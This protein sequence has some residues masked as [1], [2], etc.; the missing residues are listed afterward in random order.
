MTKKEK[1]Q[2]A[3][4]IAIV[5][6]LIALSIYLF[7]IRDRIQYLEVYGYPGIFV[8][9]LL[10]NATVIVPLP[11]VLITSAMGAVFNP[12]WVAVA[13]GTGA[14][15]GELSGY[16]AGFS[17]R[18]LIQRVSKYEKLILWMK[19]YGGVAIFLLAFIPNPAFDMAGITAGSLKVPVTRFLFW[20]LLGKF[21]KML[22][23]A[24]GGATILE[25]LPFQ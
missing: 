4:R 23:F 9:S 16:L 6:V 3:A 14:A 15:I 11:G 18:V 19:K 22:L 5:V 17:G 8:I 13:A 12:F 24:Y 10:A 20:C 21:L 25:M 1:L 2:N 7:T